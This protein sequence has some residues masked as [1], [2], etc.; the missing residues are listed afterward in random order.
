MSP[1]A[2]NSERRNTVRLELDGDRRT[3]TIVLDRPPLNV[4]D[5]EMIAGLDRAL[6]KIAEVAEGE[7]PVQAV[8]VRGAGEKAFS[9]GV[10]VAIH[11]VEQIPEMLRRFHAALEK[12][13]RLNAVTIAAVRGHCLGGGMEL[14]AICDLVVA[15]DHAR[16]G[17]PEIRVGCYP[18]VGAALYPSRVG[19][20]VAADLLLTG[21][22]I[23]ADEA[24]R[25]GFATRLVPAASFDEKLDEL[26][27]ELT[28]KSAAVTRITKKALRRGRPQHLWSTV[29][30]C[31][32]IYLTE[33]AH[34]NDVVEGVE[35]FLEKRPPRWRHA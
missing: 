6:D 10:D 12:L 30:A 34:T 16:F 22:T 17:Q 29:A 25:I 20:A 24:H 31:E 33:L 35:A 27:S 32:E 21:R 5:F 19:P 26:L 13:D 7:P 9:A 4:F 2:E 15:A 8:V 1:A 18:P 14:A 28:S 3:A 11:T 23:D